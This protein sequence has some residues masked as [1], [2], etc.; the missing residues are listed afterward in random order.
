M[1][2][3][4]FATHSLPP[5]DQFEAWREWYSPV[6]EVT[7]KAPVGDGFSGEIRLW[8]LAGWR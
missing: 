6:F 3:D 4:L 5:R 8:N 1:K 2:P 7:P